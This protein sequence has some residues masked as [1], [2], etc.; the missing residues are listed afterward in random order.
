[1]LTTR[2][3]N[4]LANFSSNKLHFTDTDCDLV[5]SV[6]GNKAAREFYQTG[7]VYK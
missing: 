2:L 1:M 5:E 6:T 7:F 4:V 3:E